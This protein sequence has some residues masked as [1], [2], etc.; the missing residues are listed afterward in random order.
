MSKE[1]KGTGTLAEKNLAD[2]NNQIAKKHDELK[3]LMQIRDMAK[4]V[5]MEEKQAKNPISNSD[6]RNLVKE[7][8]VQH[9]INYGDFNIATVEYFEDVLFYTIPE[10]ELNDMKQSIT[11]AI[12]NEISAQ[13][14]SDLNSL[15]GI[16]KDY[17]K[18][19]K[20]LPKF[21]F[22]PYKDMSIEELRSYLIVWDE[23]ISNSIR[24]KNLIENKKDRACV[25]VYAIG[26]GGT[27]IYK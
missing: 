24:G 26:K 11:N 20:R 23:N 3:K 5:L 8:L 14:E 10:A 21:D 9:F 2:I 27:Y 7:H 4:F 1:V 17:Y 25:G 18:V 22:T 12:T 19:M 15:D 13:A 6:L 16:E